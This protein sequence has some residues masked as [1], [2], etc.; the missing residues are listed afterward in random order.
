VKQVAW[1]GDW[2]SY[3]VDNYEVGT[4]N[5]TLEILGVYG[6]TDSDTVMVTVNP[7]TTATI[8]TFPI[9]SN[10]TTTSTTTNGTTFVGIQEITLIISVGSTIVIVIVIVLMLRTKQQP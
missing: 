9:T 8:D 5:Y 10:S 6:Q 1:D 4:Y 3:N 2:I 7:Q